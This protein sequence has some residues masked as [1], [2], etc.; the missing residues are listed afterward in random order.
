MNHRFLSV[1]AM[2]LI[3]S[4]AFASCKK[5][6]EKEPET[7]VVENKYYV[8][9]QIDNQVT[10]KPFSNIFGA[11]VTYTNEKGADVVLKN[12]TLPWSVTI[13]VT[14]PFTA[15]M[16]GKYIVNVGDEA[17]PD[18]VRYGHNTSILWKHASNSTWN[19]NSGSGYYSLL[20]EKFLE[21]LT[22]HPESFEFK[23]ESEIQ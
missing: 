19:S 16:T 9:Y 14:K 6:D 23:R 12:V 15:K 17:I 13:T 21:T 5:D 11:D 18:T 7:P 22:T 8:Q 2:T 4:L 1:I 10:G 20:K 3:F